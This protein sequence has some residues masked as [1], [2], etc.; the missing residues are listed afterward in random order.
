MKFVIY[1]DEKGEY[2]FRIVA[3]NNKIVAIGESY[4]RKASVYKSINK[5]IEEIQTFEIE[6]VEK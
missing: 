2:R 4:K 3:G 6:I 1:K 5:I